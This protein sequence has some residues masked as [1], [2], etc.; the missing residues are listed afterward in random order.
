MLYAALSAAVDFTTC[1]S[2][3]FHVPLPK[4]RERERKRK[5]EKR[6]RERERGQVIREIY[7]LFF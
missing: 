6:E 5:R 1:L 3:R 4:E 2:C 7:T